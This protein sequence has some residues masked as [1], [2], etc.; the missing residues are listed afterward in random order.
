[1]LRGATMQGAHGTKRKAAG[2]RD[3]HL[4]IRF[5]TS[6][7]QANSAIFEQVVAIDEDLLEARKFDC[8]LSR[9]RSGGACC[10]PSGSGLDAWEI[11]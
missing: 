10:A 4:K 2:E 1:M 9:Y 8:G 7:V 3:D 11:S 6:A 5:I